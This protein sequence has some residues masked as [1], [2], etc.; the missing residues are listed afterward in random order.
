MCNC[1]DEI[2]IEIMHERNTDKVF[3][4]NNGYSE[5]SV[6]PITQKGEYA[7]HRRY[8][9]RRWKYCPFCGEKYQD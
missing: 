7:R 1:I 9:T 2:N 8:V 4:S 6:T 3:I 5:F